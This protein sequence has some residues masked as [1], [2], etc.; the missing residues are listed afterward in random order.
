MKAHVF[1]RSLAA[2]FALAA[3]HAGPV[4]NGDFELPLGSEWT[5]KNSIPTGSATSPT[6]PLTRVAGTRTGGVG[7]WVLETTGRDHVQD[8]PVQGSFVT[9][10]LKNA[11]ITAG[12][13]RTYTARVWVKLDA[14]AAEASFR[15]VLRWRDNSVQQIP[16][17]LAESIILQ[18]GVW[19]QA[20]ATAKL[21]WVTSL[22]AATI[23][24]EV[25]QLHKGSS[26][27]PPPQ[28]FPSFQMDDLQM[29]LDGDGDGL[30]DSEESANH[31]QGTVSFSDSADSD[32]DRMT[33]DWERAQL[34]PLNPRDASD[35]ALDADGDGFSNV[36]EYFG[37]TNPHDANQY[38]G[39]P[40]DPQATFLT[41][42]LLRYLALRPSFQHAL[43]GQMVSDNSTDYT[44]YV[45]ALAT[46]TGRWPSM[47]GLA[48]EKQNAPL[49]VAASMDHAITF[50]NAGGIAQL[51]W[52]MWN[53]WRAHLYVLYQ[54]IG[55]PGDLLNIDIP[56]ILDPAGTP[57][58]AGNTAQDN[59]NARTV[60]TGWIDS[61]AAEILRYNAATGSQPLLFRPLSEMNGGWFWWGHRTRAEY[62]GLWNFIY[63]RLVA[64][65]GIHNLIWVYE[66]A[67]SEHV[68]PGA[69][70][71][72]SPSDYYYPTDA[73]VDVMSHNLYDEDWVLPFD[74]NKIYARYPKIYG[75]PQA[76]PGK[77]YPARTGAFN[78][79]IYA[80]QIA[81]RYPR[82]SFFIVWNSF[83][84]NL[85]DDNDPLTDWLN[86]DPDPLTLDD[87]HQ[88]LAIF[89]NLNPVG[90][91]N[92]AR[93]ISRD[94]LRWR[95][96]S[97]PAAVSAVSSG[98]LAAT[99]GDTS[100]AGQNESG[101]RLE[102]AANAAGPWSVAANT[103]ADVTTGNASGLPPAAA[104]WLRVR[105]LFADGSDS[106]PTDAA[107]A[108]TWSL[109]QQWKNDTLGNFAAPDLD[110]DDGDGLVT[111]LEYSLGGD[112]LA[113]SSAEQPVHAKAS[114]NGAEYL[115]LTFRR[116]IGASGVSY[117]VEAT[118]D[119]IL[120]PWLAQPVPLGLPVDHGDGTETVTFRDIVPIGAEP[121]RFLHLRVNSP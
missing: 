67:S 13:G 8:G 85:D 16:L 19:V 9:P 57:S 115:T 87:T 49:D 82:M 37:A 96:P 88:H 116:H 30:W 25:E 50:T 48:V 18:P 52:A 110:D 12:N 34:P 47:L 118:S 22:S 98:A 32:G 35:A 40:C 14:S 54:Q 24:F 36:Q 68:N 121:T 60:M 70:A 95:P 21:Q 86:D 3:A 23:D 33:D 101:F 97:N 78:N 38:P 10:T 56:G 53:P 59:L 43:V 80:D 109:F 105:S 71:N 58:I 11:L 120:G 45:A 100:I 63:D 31:A 106:L 1:L 46:Q 4:L 81:A 6:P 17:I 108:M 90:L 28:W 89:D 29:E 41:R 44:A 117:V 66:S 91:M 65:H 62:L 61:V 119:L 39:K 77:A 113:A 104:R 79:M 92:D 64:H 111:M 51:K 5:V 103:A 72:A 102:I 26:L 94:E 20:T 74:A 55:T 42:A 114:V 84:G 76:G 2:T 7:Q 93:V 75:V 15:C 107:S 83:G 112:P 73:R 69:T 99:W 27:T